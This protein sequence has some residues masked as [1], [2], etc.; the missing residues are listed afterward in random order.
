M[1]LRLIDTK[2]GYTFDWKAIQKSTFY[3][4]RSEKLNETNS[5]SPCGCLHNFNFDAIQVAGFTL[6]ISR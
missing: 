3:T 1:L 4:D 5:M 6:A 2:S